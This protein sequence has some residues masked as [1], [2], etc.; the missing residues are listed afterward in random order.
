MKA[1]AWPQGGGGTFR[2]LHSVGFWDEIEK[3]LGCDLG[4]QRESLLM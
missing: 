4:M 2:V 1:D 3:S